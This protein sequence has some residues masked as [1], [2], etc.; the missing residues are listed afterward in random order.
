MNP[1]AERVDD[2]APDP[3][4]LSLA[5]GTALTLEVR[6]AASDG[7]EFQAVG[8]APDGRV[9]RL[10]SEGADGPLV[11]GRQADDGWRLVGEVVEVI[12]VDVA[13]P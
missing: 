4:R 13:T 5:D 8:T 12:D 3:V 7:E 6:S 11:A 10:I 9:H 1:L 2:I